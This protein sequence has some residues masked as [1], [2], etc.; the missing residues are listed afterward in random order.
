MKNRVIAAVATALVVGSS[1]LLGPTTTATA[2]AI[3]SEPSSVACVQMVPLSPTKAQCDAQY[4]WDI[5]HC[6]AAYPTAPARRAIC[7][8]SAATT[9]AACLASVPKAPLGGQVVPP[10]YCS[11]CGGGGGGAG[12]W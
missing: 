4:D 11:G 9:Y 3:P 1:A 10:G 12:G 5:R 8:A 6:Q 7:Y 2:S